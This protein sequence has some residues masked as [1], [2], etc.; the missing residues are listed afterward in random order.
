MS[1]C[2]SFLNTG[3]ATRL[4]RSAIVL[5]T[6]L[7]CACA[8]SDESASNREDSGY[9]D[10]P[11]LVG[12]SW[13][14]EDVDG[15]GIVDSSNVTIGFPEQGRLAG[16]TGCNNYFGSVELA[17]DTMTLSPLGV[18]RRACA[19]SLMQQEQRFLS[20]L[21]SSIRVS[22]EDDTWLVL[23]DAARSERIRAIRA[24]AGMANGAI[25]QPVP[26]DRASTSGFSFKCPD[27]GTAS[28]RFLGP[29]TVELVFGGETYVLPRE[30]SASGAKYASG[31]VSF[32]N[33]GDEATI[34]A[35][36]SRHVCTR[37]AAE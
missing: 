18:S 28:V 12:T 32:W 16:S 10:K 37:N 14:V 30:R 21:Q 33:K 36:S 23:Y 25:S 19:A 7:V 5:L 13:Q 3:S 11:T 22:I 20:A 4:S 2:A 8:N 27:A 1:A 29:E 26:L 35:G 17:D 9:S 31:D 6:L 24:D 15:G 34:E